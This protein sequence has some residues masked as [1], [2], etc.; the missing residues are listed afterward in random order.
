[1]EF[2]TKTFFETISSAQHQMWVH[3]GSSDVPYRVSVVHVQD[4]FICITCLREHVE[5][6][7]M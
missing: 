4:V 5:V 1:M 3:R 6:R 2:V 7:K